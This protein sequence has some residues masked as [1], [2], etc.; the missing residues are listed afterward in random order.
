MGE[1]RV[2][3]DTTSEYRPFTINA[4]ASSM[5]AYF[6]NPY[7]VTMGNPVWDLQIY[8][9]KTIKSDITPLWE[10]L[11]EHA[12]Y[13][14]PPK[15]YV[16]FGY[17]GSTFCYS[18][19]N[20]GTQI[21]DFSE[22]TRKKSKVLGIW[23]ILCAP[24][25]PLILISGTKVE[26]HQDG[27]YLVDFNGSI[28]RRIDVLDKAPNAYL[29]W[30][31]Y[32]PSILAISKKS[33]QHKT[34]IYEID[35]ETGDILQK[36]KFD[37]QD[38]LPYDDLS[39]WDNLGESALLKVEDGEA[40]DGLLWNQWGS[41]SYD[42]GF[43]RLKTRIFH[44]SIVYLNSKDRLGSAEIEGIYYEYEFKVEFT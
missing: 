43:K 38:V 5:R 30:L 31:M 32:K 33:R 28:V 12:H 9:D 40:I 20:G 8:A 4:E 24:K 15:N 44:P 14:Q 34:W 2:I 6:D 16:P 25:K 19:Y 27:V 26:N 22:M 36:T 37:P 18:L 1:P 39:Y 41:Y 17:D 23:T 29:S 10:G 13:F 7:E 42:F 35:P 3:D 21:Y 11:T